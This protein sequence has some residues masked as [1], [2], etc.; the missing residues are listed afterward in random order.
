[1]LQN[2]PP[3]I[4]VVLILPNQYDI[5]VYNKL[6]F[7][8]CSVDPTS[9]V[10]VGILPSVRE[11]YFKLKIG[12]LQSLQPPILADKWRC[13][14]FIYTTGEHLLQEENFRDLAIRDEER[15]LISQALRNRSS[16]SSKHIGRREEDFIIDP[17][18]LPLIEGGWVPT[19][20]RIDL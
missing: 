4:R 9:L 15:G 12:W 11:E 10:L 13:L 8:M 1:M 7:M 3:V 20:P 18:L 16:S 17:E 6:N 19:F 14:T 5:I 2:Q